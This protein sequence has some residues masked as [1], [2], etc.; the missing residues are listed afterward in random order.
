MSVTALSHREKA[1]EVFFR[2]AKEAVATH[3][4]LLASSAKE[5]EDV[6]CYWWD[7]IKIYYKFWDTNTADKEALKELQGHEIYIYIY[8]WGD[9]ERGL[10]L[11]VTLLI[12][13]LL[14]F[15]CIVEPILRTNE[16]AQSP[17][18]PTNSQT[19]SPW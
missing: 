8:S 18:N 15:C 7:M 6:S 3:T 19:N 13:V 11:A 17:G 2:E 9:R 10:C 5:E 14:Y 12:Y 4:M 16:I 1:V